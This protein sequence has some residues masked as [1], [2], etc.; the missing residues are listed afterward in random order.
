MMDRACERNAPFVAEGCDRGAILGFDPGVDL[1]RKKSGCQRQQER[2]SAPGPE[3]NRQDQQSR[4]FDS[5]QPPCWFFRCS[6][7]GA[8][9]V[10]VRVEIRGAPPMTCTWAGS[11][12][13]RP[14]GS[15]ASA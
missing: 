2:S 13:G 8:G 11:D 6:R 10:T 14:L 5:C 4:L 15:A 7:D 12:L 1:E 9:V 3:K